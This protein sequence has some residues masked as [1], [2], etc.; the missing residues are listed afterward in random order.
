MIPIEEATKIV[1]DHSKSYGEELVPLSEANGRILRQDLLAD[2]DFPP[3]T[4]VTM[5]GIAIRYNAYANG[6]RKF[7]IE[8]MQAAGSPQRRLNDLDGC[9][10]VMTGAI[11]PENTDT[12]IRYED[13]KIENGTAKLQINEVKKGQ[14]AH[15]RAFDRKEGEVIVKA[16]AI[17]SPAEIGVAATVGLSSLKVAKLPTV[18]IIST[19]DELVEVNE[20]PEP[21]Q[22]RT[23]NV[24]TIA[25]TLYRWG[26]RPDKL[27][28]ADDMDVTVAKLSD[29][30]EKYDVLILSGG[31]SK[32]KFDY[33]PSALHTLG[34]KKLFHKVK[35]R[36]G[37][38]FWF[39]ESPNG[40]VI[41][42]LPGNPVSA[43]MCAM[44]Y[45]RP[46]IR[47]SMELEPMDYAH[48]VLAED[49]KFKPD[50]TYFLQV[51]TAFDAETGRL[52]A[53]PVEGHG[54]GDLA[55]LVDA[56]AFLE[57]PR[58]KDKFKKGKVFPLIFY[59]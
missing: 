7:T 33:I 41:F 34:M 8:G 53:I 39:G 19:G 50:L 51:H 22:I 42:A 38:P 16:G 44:R 15:L 55:N 30:L 17:I 9:L 37:K 20:T 24:Y 3:F 2:R 11:L 36:P 1:L 18:A 59:R 25:S 47:K 12:V 14:N 31:V 6:Q 43:F 45:L 56:D 40:K 13:V 29:C 46:W 52:M 54:S 28:I 23:S 58:G 21:H 48:A 5:D 35:Q 49:F 26:I 4:R 57:L 32:G 10:E 27:H